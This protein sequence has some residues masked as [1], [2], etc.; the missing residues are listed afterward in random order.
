M[1]ASG[2]ETLPNSPINDSCTLYAVLTQITQT[3]YKL[4]QENKEKIKRILIAKCVLTTIFL[5]LNMETAK[6]I[7][8]QAIR[9][10]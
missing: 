10:M 1:C 2:F 8:L 3:K 6:G 9:I 4:G 7:A 5:T